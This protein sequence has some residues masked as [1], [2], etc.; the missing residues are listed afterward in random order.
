MHVQY[1]AHA[2][3]EGPWVAHGSNRQWRHAHWGWVTTS[4]VILTQSSQ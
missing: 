3:I 4:Q 1:S 2:L